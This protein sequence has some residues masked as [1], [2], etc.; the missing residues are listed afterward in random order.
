MKKIFICTTRALAGGL[1]LTLPVM[2]A[3]TNT[4]TQADTSAA[5]ATPAPAPSLATATQVPTTA[6]RLPYGAEDVVKLSRAQISDDVIINYVRNSGTAYNL[7]PTDI[8]QLRNDGVSDQVIK[9]MMDQKNHLGDYAANQSAAAQQAVPAQMT[10]PNVATAPLTPAP[11]VTTAPAS[12]VYVIPSPSVEAAY[13]GPYYD[14]YY[15]SPYAYYGSP[16][17]YGY[18][19][20]G[21]SL[22]FRFGGGRY[23]GGHYYG[24]HYGGGHYGGGHYGGGG[25]FGHR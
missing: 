25:H 24:G 19:G 4:A 14:P 20:P 23:Y 22:G 11:A 12:S 16:Y 2:A 17:Y 15:Y 13:Y 6:N 7:Q 21:I 18:Y 3:D 8:V 5:Q 1:L 10:A 9:A